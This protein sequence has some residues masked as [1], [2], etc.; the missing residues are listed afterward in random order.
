M[1]ALC[2]LYNVYS[3]LLIVTG[4]SNRR[5][6]SIVNSLE[7][8]GIHINHDEKHKA[9]IAWIHSIHRI[10]S[11]ENHSIYRKVGLDVF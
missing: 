5:D 11:F 4:S 1:A 8:H 6:A 10:T 9:T 3:A 2:F 7:V